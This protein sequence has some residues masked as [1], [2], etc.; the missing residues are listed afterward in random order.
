MTKRFFPE[1]RPSPVNWRGHFVLSKQRDHLPEGWDAYERNGWYLGVGQLPVHPVES[2]TG[3]TIGWCLGYPIKPPGAPDSLILQT[4]GDRLSICAGAMEA[5]YEQLAGRFILIVLTANE[6]KL[7]LDPYGSL[8]VVYLETQPVVAS[9]PALLPQGGDWNDDLLN[10][11]NIPE[12]PAYL[13]FGLTSRRGVQRLLP[14]HFLD[15]RQ[16]VCQRHW[17]ESPA[18]LE[19]DPD[20]SAGVGKIAHCLRSTMASLA[21]RHPLQLSLTAG[22]DSRMVLACAREQLADISFFTFAGENESVDSHIARKLAGKLQTTHRFIPI[23]E[24]SE[25]ELTRWLYKTGHA[26]GGNIWRIH[27]TLEHLDPQSVLLN[28]I[29]GEVGRAFYWRPGDRADRK[30]SADQLLKRVR[31][32]RHPQILGQA[33]NWLSGLTGYN[34]FQV[35][36]LHYLEQRLGCWASPQ[37]YGNET[38]LFEMSPFNHRPVFTSMMRLPYAYR[39]RQHLATDLCRTQ[40]PELLELPFNEFTGLR[41]YPQRL[42]RAGKAVIKRILGSL[43][44]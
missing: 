23:Q 37:H 21:T 14:N 30:L 38:S 40:W 8:G 26:L 22:R 43:R 35:L 1:Q 20:P 11:L 17:P 29:G 16:W 10:A 27:K 13:P 39:R 28:G 6:E 15:L 36:D 7:F 25:G 33:E 34:L 9:A 41:K 12:S 24:A 42:E 3:E 31:F 19:V 4:E 2:S 5:F 32:P 18:S 44:R